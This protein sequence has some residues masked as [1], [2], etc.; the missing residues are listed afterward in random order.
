M[1]SSVIVTVQ[2]VLDSFIVN[3]ENKLPERIR[4]YRPAR[5]LYRV[6]ST[7]A[8]NSAAPCCRVQWLL[9]A[10]GGGLLPFLMSDWSSP[11]RTLRGLIAHLVLYFGLS[12]CRR[13][14]KMRGAH[15]SGFTVTLIRLKFSYYLN[16]CW[17]CLS[18]GKA[19]WVFC[20]VLGS[21]P[22]SKRTGGRLHP[23]FPW[24]D[25]PT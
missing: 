15:S 8:S 2:F 19:N 1:R 9:A 20:F 12:L 22:H 5:L 3:K 23:S 11:E 24:R 25:L 7:P 10:S 6:L 18:A 4:R 17:Q 16:T 14:L 13:D 21:I